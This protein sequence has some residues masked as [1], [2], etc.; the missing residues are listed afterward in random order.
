[1][2]IKLTTAMSPKQTPLDALFFQQSPQKRPSGIVESKQV[3]AG[4][5]SFLLKKDSIEKSV[6][7]IIKSA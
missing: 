7:F 6:K 1:M 3:S 5:A 2:E 4:Y